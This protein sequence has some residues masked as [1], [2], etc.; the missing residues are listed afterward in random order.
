M[1]VVELVSDIVVDLY[2]AVDVYNV[3]MEPMGVDYIGLVFKQIDIL[4]SVM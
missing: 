4:V 2:Q 1:A 3:L